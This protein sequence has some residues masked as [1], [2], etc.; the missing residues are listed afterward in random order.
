[1]I[2]WVLP[3]TRATRED[4]RKETYF[5]SERWARSR[6][7]GEEANV[8]L[9]KHM[10]AFIDGKGI[11]AV[12]PL[13]SPLWESKTSEKYAYA[14]TWSERHAA[15]AAGL[16]TFGLCDGLITAKGKAHRV[17]SVVINSYVEPTERLY[18]NHHAYCLFY[19]EGNCRKCMERCPIGAI[20]EN[21]HD[22]YLCRKY[23]RMT[24]QYVPRHFGFEGY[25]CGFCQT[26][27]PC[28]S[29]I[30]KSLRPKK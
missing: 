3:Q 8:K 7:F 4:H 28:E 12:A 24:H 1:V 23:V 27:I 5:P 20:S 6:I 25:G 26:S 30:P 18:D 21:G 15:Y 17:G 16:G 22:K 2:S 13:V 29:A 10:E 11:E 9:R 14:S 19:M